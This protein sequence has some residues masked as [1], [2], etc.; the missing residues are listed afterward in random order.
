MLLATGSRPRMFRPRAKSFADFS[1][2]P[3]G[4]W[5]D[6]PRPFLRRFA[7]RR[8]VVSMRICFQG[9]EVAVQRAM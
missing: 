9:N 7:T 8:D 4:Q 3:V 5:V 2:R 6:I 1:T